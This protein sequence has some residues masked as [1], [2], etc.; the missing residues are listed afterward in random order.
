MSRMAEYSCLML[1][2]LGDPS[3]KVLVP[4]QENR[5]HIQ[6]IRSSGSEFFC[7]NTACLGAEAV[8]F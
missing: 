7:K 3:G 2:N 8:G 6:G 1:A 5:M 4:P